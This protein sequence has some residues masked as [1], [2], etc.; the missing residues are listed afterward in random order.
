[1]DKFSNLLEQIEDTLDEADLISEDMRKCL[2]A[3]K[4]VKS[5]LEEK[6]EASERSAKNLESGKEE[7]AKSLEA[8]KEKS[9]VQTQALGFVKEILTSPLV[10]DEST[11]KLYQAIDN[12]VAFIKDDVQEALKESG[13]LRDLSDAERRD[14]FVSDLEAWAIT[15][16]KKWI[17]GKTTIALLGEFSAGKT[18]ILNC[19]LSNSD[20]S[21][22]QLPVEIRPTTAIPTYISGGLI[23]R[24][25]FVTPNN[26]LK[27]LSEKTFKRVSKEILAQVDGVSSLIQYF[28]M[29]CKNSNLN[30]LSILDTPGF[31]STDNEDAERSIGVINECDALFWV[32][33]ISAGDLNESSLTILKKIAVHNKPLYIILNQIDQKSS[34]ELKRTECQFKRT[35]TNNGIKYEGILHFSKNLKE[36]LTPLMETILLIKHDD[37]RETYLDKIVNLLQKAIDKAKEAR[38]IAEQEKNGIRRTYDRVKREL[39]DEIDNILEGCFKIRNLPKFNKRSFSADDFRLT[40]EEHSDFVKELGGVC[41]N[42]KQVKAKFEELGK[43]G[44]KMA[45]ASDVYH[46]VVSRVNQLERCME[47]LEAKEKELNRLSGRPTQRNESEHRHQWRPP[48]I[49]AQAEGGVSTT[50]EDLSP[51]EIEDI[52]SFHGC[53]EVESEKPV[54]KSMVELFNR[55][56]ESGKWPKDDED[57]DDDDDDENDDEEENDEDEAEKGGEKSG[58]ASELT[59]IIANTANKKLFELLFGSKGQI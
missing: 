17:D 37:G 32:V 30:K 39:R 34:G 4:K 18:S 59:S 12:I 23:N 57:D 10:S 31:N 7:V 8:E 27:E 15:K 38:L 16:K 41:E 35:L 29:T 6:I 54:F 1:M 58:F 53:T 26:E 2:D 5:D 14:L 44:G 25:Q 3:L 28:V 50:D 36:T 52:E 55:L 24:Y 33:N 13:Q 21:A 11:I 20:S 51:E 45:T 43:L 40:Q 42:C 22:P 9:L 46:V 47:S 56:V 19:I 48:H 49:V